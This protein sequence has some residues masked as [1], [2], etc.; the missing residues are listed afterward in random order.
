MTVTRA[1]LPIPLITHPAQ[2]GSTDVVG[3][4]AAITM[5]SSDDGDFKR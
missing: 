2:S 4:R 5:R 1:F 3:W